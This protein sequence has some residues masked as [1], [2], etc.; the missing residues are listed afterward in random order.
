MKATLLVYQPS[1]YLPASRTGRLCM[2]S[3]LPNTR[4]IGRSVAKAP[5]A[6]AVANPYT[7]AVALLLLAIFSFM[8]PT[9]KKVGTYKHSS[10]SKGKTA[11]PIP[12]A[13]ILIPV[14]K[15][16]EF[17]IFAEAVTRVT[18]DALWRRIK[19][20]DGYERLRQCKD[21]SPHV[22]PECA[23]A[24]KRFEYIRTQLLQRLNQL[25]GGGQVIYP[26]LAEAA[27][28]LY[29]GGAYIGRDCIGYV[30]ALAEVRKCFKCTAP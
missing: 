12:P 24:W 5:V 7:L 20:E 18:A 28:V 21:L 4:R 27:T 17:L 13:G 19:N 11:V 9:Q 14:V 1:T 10:P 23:E 6:G 25:R 16:W 29:N 30:K 3:Y 2:A 8:R 26:K 15:A 22:S